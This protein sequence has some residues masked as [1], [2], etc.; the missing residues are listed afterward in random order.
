MAVQRRSRRKGTG[1][2]ISIRLDH[3]TDQLVA[4][5]ARRTR[6]SRSAIVQAYTEETARVRRFPGMGFRGDDASRRAWVIGSGLDVWEIAQ[7]LE[8]FGSVSRLVAETHLSERQVRL[9]IAYRD[10]FPD[11]ISDAI[12]Q[13]RRGV[14]ELR[15]LYPFVQFAGQRR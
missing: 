9:V 1:Q 13:N 7:M 15:T 2:P 8:D 3:A 12:E 10:A 5:E 6:R 11:E 4:A 14:D